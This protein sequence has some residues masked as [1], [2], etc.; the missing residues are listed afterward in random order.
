MT[1]DRPLPNASPQA[2]QT[3]P[4]TRAPPRC[5]RSFGSV[6]VSAGRL[7]QPCC[8][9]FLGHPRRIGDL[10]KL[11]SLTSKLR[12]KPA[13]TTTMESLAEHECPHRR[14]P[15][16]T[17]LAIEHVDR[18]GPKL[19]NRAGHR[20]AQVG[21][22]GTELKCSASAKSLHTRRSRRPHSVV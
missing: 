11:A 13:G 10:R 22:K 1:Q 9:H 12:R 19:P 18:R 14:R 3:A 15:R 8:Q 2:S 7:P 4:T 21:T 17:K 20:L 5:H 16:R 6:Q